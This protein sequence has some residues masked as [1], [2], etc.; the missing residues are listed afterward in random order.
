MPWAKDVAP[1]HV[2]GNTKRV[3]RE[4]KGWNFIGRV[5]WL[6]GEDAREECGILNGK[7]MVF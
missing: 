2:G 6:A 5:A 3:F 1:I 7:E 4:T